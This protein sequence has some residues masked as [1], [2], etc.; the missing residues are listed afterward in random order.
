[1]P[2]LHSD[3]MTRATKILILGAA[4][5]A[6]VLF[7]PQSVRFK[8]YHDDTDT[9][10]SGLDIVVTLEIFALMGF[11]AMAFEEGREHEREFWK[12][13]LEKRRNLT[14]PGPSPSVPESPTSRVP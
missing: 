9:E 3:K 4:I 12:S 13:E 5:I 2:L 14:A 8:Y 7:A 10:R 11:F 1:M 6:G